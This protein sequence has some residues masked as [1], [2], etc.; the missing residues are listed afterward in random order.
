M[1]HW[2]ATY[3]E[4]HRHFHLSDRFAAS[5]ERKIIFAFPGSETDLI[6]E[7]P[8]AIHGGEAVI[9]LPRGWTRE[10]P[11]AHA[12]HGDRGEDLAATG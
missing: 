6:G 12:L 2:R 4:C 11:H 5:Q 10:P 3:Q 8:R 7:G 9:P 1:M